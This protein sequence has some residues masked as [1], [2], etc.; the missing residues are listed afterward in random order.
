MSLS[1]SVRSR[2]RVMFSTH[3]RPTIISMNQLRVR[4][5]VHYAHLRLKNISLTMLPVTNRIY[6][7]PAKGSLTAQEPHLILLKYI[8]NNYTHLWSECQEEISS[9]LK[10]HIA[11]HR[12]AVAVAIATLLK[13]REIAMATFFFVYH[14]RRKRVKYAISS[15]IGFLCLITPPSPSFYLV[16]ENLQYS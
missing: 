14:H 1:A 4:P 12:S 13:D 7:V 6:A 10:G 8:F 2:A 11:R 5:Y 3:W 16:A 15:V 9:D